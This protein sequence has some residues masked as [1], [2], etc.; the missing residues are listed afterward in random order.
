MSDIPV[1][2]TA[3]TGLRLVEE[4]PRIVLALGAAQLLLTLVTS[5]VLF[6]FFGRTFAQLATPLPPGAA[7]PALAMARLGAMAPIFG[8]I[9]IAILVFYG[10]LSAAMNRAVLRPQDDAFG[11]LRFGA[12]ELRQMGLMLLLWLLSVAFGV[13][14]MI[15]LGILLGLF[16][17]LLHL[18]ALAV[19]PPLYLAMLGLMMFVAV[20][21][22]LASADTFAL[23]RISVFGSWTIS[24]GH[25]WSM[26]G[27]YLLSVF[28]AVV[29]TLVCFFAIFAV[30]YLLP[31]GGM[32]GLFP[33][34]G[35]AAFAARFTVA[36][37]VQTILYAA[38]QGVILPVMLT[39]A[40]AI[41]RVLA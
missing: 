31:G 7:S 15:A 34:P 10:V 6:V 27:V 29:I 39:P 20:R 23:G 37:I 25:F 30:T 33:H 36:G 2:D 22:S 5:I 32:A 12:D 41:Y 9:W 26:F 1:T 24:R 18:G 35:A 19:M 17:G 40:P 13:A 28:L 38:V 16:I 11:Y 3:M 4:R 21:F 14:V 8:F